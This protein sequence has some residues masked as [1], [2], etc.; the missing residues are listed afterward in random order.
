[1]QSLGTVVRCRT[2]ESVLMVDVD[3]PGIKCIDLRGL[4]TL[5]LVR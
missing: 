3:I 4:A 5:E 1:V 2:C